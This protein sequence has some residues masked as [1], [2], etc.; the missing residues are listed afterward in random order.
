MDHLQA[1]V[2]RSF[3]VFPESSAFFQP[4]EGPL[5]DPSLGHDGEGM[6]FVALGDLHGGAEFVLD[7]LGKRLAGV[8]A[9]DQHAADLL[10]VVRAAVERCQSTLAVGHIGCRYGYG[11]RQ[12][13]R[14][15][16][17]VALDAGDLLARVIALLAGGIGVLHALRVHDQEAGRGAASLSGALLANR[18]F[19]RPVPGR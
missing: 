18:F 16:R 10:E 1:G 9:I 14:I 4:C 7:R 2:E 17:D 6:Q 8:A 12:A 13:L 11:V 5:D 15:H 3:A 19:L